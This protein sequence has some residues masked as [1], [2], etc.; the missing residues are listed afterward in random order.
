MEDLAEGGQIDLN[1]DV[2]AVPVGTALDEDRPPAPGG[3]GDPVVY[4][5]D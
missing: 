3:K 2:E 4:D 1:V 5:E